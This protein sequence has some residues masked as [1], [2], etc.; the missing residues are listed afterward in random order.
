ME[1]DLDPMNPTCR[2]QVEVVEYRLVADPAP[3]VTWTLQRR[4]SSKAGS[5]SF[6]AAT[7]M[8]NPGNWVPFVENVLNNPAV[9]ADAVFTYDCTG[10]APERI[11]SVR[12][13]LRV[14]S[15][16]PEFRVI[17]VGGMTRRMSPN[18]R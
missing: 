5:S 11:R 15:S 10:C 16:R 7:C 1:L 8:P 3:A 4:V 18:I 17:T 12:I 2:E 14:Q 9:P 6:S 13:Q